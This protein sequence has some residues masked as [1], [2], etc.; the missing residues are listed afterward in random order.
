MVK[1]YD[2]VGGIWRTIGGR[3]VF[4]KTGQSLEDAM[5]ESGKFKTKDRPTSDV[6]KINE[7]NNK[8]TER[9]EKGQKTF[10]PVEFEKWR[11]EYDPDFT[12]SDDSARN[13]YELKGQPKAMSSRTFADDIKER[14]DERIAKQIFKFY[15][16][17]KMD[18]YTKSERRLDDGKEIHDVFRQM[19]Y[20]EMK[21]FAQEH[22]DS[23]KKMQEYL[24]SKKKN[25]K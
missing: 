15:G 25:K 11:Q 6:D 14:D 9:I 16:Y 4:I 8:I 7:K 19:D 23:I 12:M 18:D 24:K 2:D 20:K 17:D 5:K 22:P 3:R 10:D 21:A 13:I 1:K